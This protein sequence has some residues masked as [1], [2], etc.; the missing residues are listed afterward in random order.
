MKDL[1]KDDR[2]SKDEIDEIKRIAIQLK[3]LKEEDLKK[4]YW[5]MEGM[6]MARC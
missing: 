6:K 4:M 3:D 2:Y 5:L 1:R